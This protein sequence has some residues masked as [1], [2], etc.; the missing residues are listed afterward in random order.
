MSNVIFLAHRNDSPTEVEEMLCCKA[1]KNRTFTAIYRNGIESFP[2]L[3]CAACGNIAGEFGWV[4][5][6]KG[7]S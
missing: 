7:T 1:C 3:Q 2:A 4:G 5:D 6:E